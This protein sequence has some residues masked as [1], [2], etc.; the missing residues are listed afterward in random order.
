M[1]QSCTYGSVRGA[2]GDRRPYRD[3]R[4]GRRKRLPH[5]GWQPHEEARWGRRFRLPS[6]HLETSFRSVLARFSQKPEKPA[7]K[8]DCLRHLAKITNSWGLPLSDTTAIDSDSLDLL[9]R[10]C[11]RCPIR[12]KDRPQRG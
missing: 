7:R 4:L 12:R 9:C 1:Q 5:Q 8:Q 3:K 11:F 2:P 10:A 6:A